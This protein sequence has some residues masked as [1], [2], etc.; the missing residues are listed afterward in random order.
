MA[1]T[2][3]AFLTG[4]VVETMGASVTGAAFFFTGT[5]TIGASVTGAAFFLTGAGVGTMGAS[6]VTGAAS[7]FALTGAAFFLTGSDTW[8]GTDADFECM[9]VV[10]IR[11][12][13]DDV[14]IMFG[15]TLGEL[16]MAVLV[17]PKPSVATTLNDGSSVSGVSETDLASG[18]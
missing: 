13:E 4:A 5:E 9:A 16:T 10:P 8:V 18:D 1:F 6:A 2:G 12:C 17:L 7:T 15:I 3:A 11:S 14:L